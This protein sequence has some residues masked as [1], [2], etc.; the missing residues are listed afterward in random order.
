MLTAYF[1]IKYPW[2]V[3]GGIAASAPVLLFQDLVGSNAFSVAA[4]RDYIEALPDNVCGQ[5][6]KI[7]KVL[8]ENTLK[9]VPSSDQLDLDHVSSFLSLVNEVFLPCHPLKSYSDIKTYLFP[10]IGNVLTSAAMGNYP[11]PCTFMGV[12]PANPVNVTCSYFTSPHMNDKQILVA[13]GNAVRMFYNSTMVNS[14]YV[15]VGKGSLT[16][17][18]V[19]NGPSS[20][21]DPVSQ[22]WGLQSCNEMVMP[23]GQ[24]GP[25]GSPS[26][27]YYVDQWNLTQI[28]QTCQ[29]KPFLTKPRPYWIPLQF[30]G[31]VL[32][33]ASNIVFSNGGFDPWHSGGILKSISKSV[34]AVWI[35]RGG[36]HY[37]LRASHPKDFPEVVEARRVHKAYIKAWL[38]DKP[39]PSEEELSSLSSA[40]ISSPPAKVLELS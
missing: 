4:S 2:I 7:W 5:F 29:Q 1:R 11:Y 38:S 17:N 9:K 30:G 23:L 18:D 27:I 34:P 40:R 25:S 10:Y 33:G 16:C 14:S 32:E 3:S 19:G 35:P 24:N 13:V 8:E 20:A 31:A 22:A 21:V 36:H 12:L 6:G 28:V 26:D 37:D 39:A 15:E